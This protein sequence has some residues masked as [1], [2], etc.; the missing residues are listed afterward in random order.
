MFPRAASGRVPAGAGSG[1]GAPGCAPGGC[2]EQRLAPRAP[3]SELG[4]C[5]PGSER[6]PSRSP[7][8]RALG[9]GRT[10]AQR[11]AQAWPARGHPPRAGMPVAQVQSPSPARRRGG[12]AWAQPRRELLSAEPSARFA[13]AEEGPRSLFAKRS[14]ASA[15]SSSWEAGRAGAEDS[16]PWGPAKG[17]EGTAGDASGLRARARTASSAQRSPRAQASGHARFSPEPFTFQVS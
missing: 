14:A 3:L 12:E 8:A 5:A 17:A 11:D 16:T 1:P 6:P 15:L 13:R 7:G 2:R 10:G 9:L 4:R